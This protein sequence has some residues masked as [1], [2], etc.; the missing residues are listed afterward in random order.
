LGWHLPTKVVENLAKKRGVRFKASIKCK[1]RL[2]GH[3]HAVVVE[4]SSKEVNQI[5]EK[6][7]AGRQKTAERALTGW[8]RR[9]F[10]RK[11]RSKVSNEVELQQKGQLSRHLR[12]GVV[13][14]LTE[15]SGIRF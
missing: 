3:L 5:S 15:K 1:R 10:S 12:S 13:E 11:V 8:S 9:Q 2:S 14:A 4:N 6:N 7:K